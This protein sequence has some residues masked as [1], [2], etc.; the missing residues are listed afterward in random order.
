MLLS[1]LFPDR[2]HSNPQ[3][4][5]CRIKHDDD[6][7][8][9]RG[10]QRILPL[11]ERVF[12]QRALITV[13]VQGLDDLFTSVILEVNDEGEYLVMDELRPLEGHAALRPGHEVHV[14]S[15]LDGIS[16]SF[17]STVERIEN[18]QAGAYYKVPLPAE[19]RYNQKR[20]YYRAAVPVTRTSPVLLVLGDRRSLA[21]ELRDISLGGFS[22]RLNPGAPH[23]VT[24]GDRIDRC[25]L[26]LDEQRSIETAVEVCYVEDRA[27]TRRPRFGLRFI[28][29]DER[30]LRAIGGLVATLE[31]D[32]LRSAARAG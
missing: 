17:S 14:S 20:N 28:D 26:H 15:R 3:P 4:P 31:R 32:Q 25:I 2:S 18:E 21:G 23:G 22:M 8:L 7:E 1:A 5:A 13:A 19:L 30:A 12:R 9:L 27:S 16:L 10:S 6:A 11:V 29:L 24:E